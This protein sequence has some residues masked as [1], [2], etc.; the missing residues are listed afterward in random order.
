[1]QLREGWPGLGRGAA[2]HTA[3][4]GVTR[5]AE[6]RSGRRPGASLGGTATWPARLARDPAQ[7]GFALENRSLMDS[8]R[9]LAAPTCG[10]IPK[11]ASKG[12]V[13]SLVETDMIRMGMGPW[14]R[15]RSA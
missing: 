6:A 5:R 12:I 7:P 4:P 9:T 10:S 3:K 11:N 14:T 2:A 1:M 8:P 13:S 15:R